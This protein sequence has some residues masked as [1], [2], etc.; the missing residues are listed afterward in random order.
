M[1]PI[2]V[3]MLASVIRPASFRDSIASPQ[4]SIALPSAPLE[5]N[6]RKTNKV[7]SLA[8]VLAG[9]WPF[10]TIFIVS[11]TSNQVLPALNAN[12]IS[13]S[14]MPW[15]NA[16][17]APRIFKWLSV[18]TTTAPGSASPSSISTCEPIPRSQSKTLIPCSRANSRQI[19]WLFAQGILF[20]GTTQS[21]V[22]NVFVS[23]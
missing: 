18:P 9:S 1:P 19:C 3:A 20:A 10:I 17:M 14:P 11:G 22:K 21:K 12:A 15:P 13:W 23:L 16:P 2:S 6:L 7:K 5:P 4:N 8:V